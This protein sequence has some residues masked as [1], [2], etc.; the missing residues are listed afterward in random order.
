MDKSFKTESEVWDQLRLNYGDECWG[1][2]YRNRCFLVALCPTPLPLPC[3][4]IQLLL[5]WIFLRSLDLISYNRWIVSECHKN[6]FKDWCLMN[7]QSS[8]LILTSFYLSE[9][10]ILS[11]RPKPDKFESH[12][13]LKLSFTDIW[14]LH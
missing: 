1:S 13:S 9:M 10:A 14:G 11:K 12:N 6:Y 7:W 4:S 2:R 5:G 8:F 3:V